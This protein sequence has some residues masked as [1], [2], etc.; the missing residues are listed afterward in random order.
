MR[1]KSYLST[2]RVLM[3]GVLAMP[4]VSCEEDDEQIIECVDE[5]ETDK[6]LLKNLKE[7]RYIFNYF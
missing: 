2:L 1:K 5:S 7:I 3:L 6:I 4:I